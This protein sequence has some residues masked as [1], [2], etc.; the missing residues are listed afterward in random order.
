MPAKPN[1]PTPRVV[2]SGLPGNDQWQSPKP[3]SLSAPSAPERFIR[4]D[5]VRHLVGLG[6]TIIYEMIAAGHFPA[7][8]KV[9]SAALWS[10]QEISTWIEDIKRS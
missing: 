5:E 1:S 6:K 2:T 3:Q 9:S 8:Y 7:P 4:L 10:Q